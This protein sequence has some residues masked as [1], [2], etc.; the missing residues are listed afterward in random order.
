MDAH[1]GRSTSG[2]N[3]QRKMDRPSPRQFWLRSA[4][5]A[6][7]LVSCE[8]G[9]IHWFGIDYIS[10]VVSATVLPFSVAMELIFSANDPPKPRMGTA[11]YVRA[12]SVL[13]V[14]GGIINAL[15]VYSARNSG[16][17]RAATP[18]PLCT[19]LAPMFGFGIWIEAGMPLLA[20]M[21]AT[22]YLGRTPNAAP[23]RLRFPFLLGNASILTAVWFWSGWS[24]GTEYQGS[25][26]VLTTLVTNIAWLLLL[27]SYWIQASANQEPAGPT[28]SRYAS[29]PGENGRTR[30]RRFASR[31]GRAGEAACSVPEA[32]LTS[33]Q[34]ERRS[35]EIRVVLRARLSISKLPGP[36]ARSAAGRLIPSNRVGRRR[37]FT[38]I[39]PAAR[40]ARA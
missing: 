15:G 21:A 38:A 33:P 25:A 28:H 11:R 20:F 30:R 18:L 34:A 12:H 27:W 39:R 6:I 40:P 17:P 35:D 36:T 23:I 26:Y 3:K 22:L 32:R 24:F 16:V 14:G 19:I 29:R 13:V 9:L 4:L 7:G 1:I 8:L 37:F 31:R 2:S 10:V 5:I